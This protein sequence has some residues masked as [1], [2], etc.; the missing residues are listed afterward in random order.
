EIPGRRIDTAN[1]HGSGCAFSAAIAA[2]L[3]RGMEPLDAVREAKL[4]ITAAIEN[5][6]EIGHGHG[7]VNPM[8]THRGAG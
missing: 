3:A 7:P 4:F 2:G 5:S 1:T 6:L 8:A